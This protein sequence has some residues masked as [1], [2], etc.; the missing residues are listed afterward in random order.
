[1]LII[2]GVGDWWRRYARISVIVHFIYISII[3]GKVLLWE[4]AW[5]EDNEFTGWKS[6]MLRRWFCLC[7]HNAWICVEKFWSN[8]FASTHRFKVKKSFLNWEKI[9]SVNCLPLRWVKQI[10]LKCFTISNFDLIFFVLYTFWL[11]RWNDVLK[12]NLVF[13]LRLYLRKS[14]LIRLFNIETILSIIRF[15]INS[16]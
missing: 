4:M 9:F 3:N 13:F 1:M 11:C 14:S 15:G 2:I 6:F 10:I 12:I 8:Y 7:I 16:F 5:E